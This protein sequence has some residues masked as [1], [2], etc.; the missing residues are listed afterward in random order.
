MSSAIEKII[1]SL[2]D[3][4]REHDYK[5]YILAQPVVS[6]Q[7]YDKLLKELEKLESEHPELITP[8]SPTQRV[9][10]DLTKEFK[11]V[12]HKV[13]MLSLSNT[14]SEDELFDFD[15]RVKEGL[16]SEDKVEYLVELKIDGASVSINF[17]NG[18]L[19]T[20][21]TR[22]D[23]TIGEEITNNVRT[24]K[25]IPLKVKKDKSIPYKLNDFEVRGEIFMNIDDFENLN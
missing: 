23:G 20:A 10:S 14:Y 24:I 25:S 4:I 7:E 9:G 16:A 19:K 12:E 11:P 3:E 5:Y 17:V 21:S 18:F 15:R 8:D 6:D 1:S 22:G 2:R 13:P